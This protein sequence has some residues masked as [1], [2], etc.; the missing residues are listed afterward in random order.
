VQAPDDTSTGSVQVEVTTSGGTATGT[1]DLR[2]VSP[3]LF[4]A[5]QTGSGATGR[6]YPAAQVG[7]NLTGPSNLIPGALAA[8]GGEIVV[9]WATG[10]GPTA[11]SQA[12]GRV[13]SVAPVTAP[14]T[15]T[16]GGTRAT[17]LFAGLVGAGLYQV[18]VTIPVGLGSGERAVQL[19]QNGVSSPS[20]V[21]LLLQ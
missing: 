14:V 7:G 21:Y 19:T 16:I 8:R 20:N 10:L 13:P 5:A 1:A 9:L 4:L 6:S 2:T 18:N 11:P 17:V 3:G 12:A 15:V